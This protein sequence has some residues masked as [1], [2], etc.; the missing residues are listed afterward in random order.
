MGSVKDLALGETHNLPIRHEGNVHNGKVRS[1]YWL[2]PVDSKRIIE[3]ENYDINPESQLGVMIISDRISAFDVNWKSSQGLEGI[4][5]KGASLNAISYHWFKK[6]QNENLAG[7][8]I[9]AAPHPLVWIVQKA[10]PIMIEAIARS[11]ITGSMWRK[12]EKGE[13]EFCGID[14]PDGLEKNQKLDKILITPTTKG[15]LR[16]IPGVPEKDDINITRVQIGINSRAFGFKNLEDIYQYEYL[17]KMGFSFIEE[18]LKGV[19]QLFVDT[20]FEFGYI[21]DKKGIPSMIY[22]DEI[23]TPDSSRMWDAKE[24]SNGKVVENSKEGF[25]QFLLNDSGIDKDILL[26]SERFDERKNIA[27]SY[28]V[29]LNIMNDV[30]DI[31]T[32]MAEKITGKKMLRI[33]E[34]KNEII[35]ALTKY[36]V[37]E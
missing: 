32:G 2:N 19:G 25:R 33:F 26:N 12:Y 35:D 15:I 21:T 16:G 1:V 11:Y 31:Y 28:K 8:H 7:N 27:F 24:Y 34:P 20:K 4:P 22:I 6:F 10:E 9:L 29:P 5:G 13:R 30:S 36:N 3:Q 18:E 14:I 37:V 23:G 17:L